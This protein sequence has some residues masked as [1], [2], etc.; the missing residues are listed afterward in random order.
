[1]PQHRAS[2][3]DPSQSVKQDEIQ[4]LTSL[5]TPDTMDQP[6]ALMSNW[7]EP[8]FVL[9]LATW[10]R[11][12]ALLVCPVRGRVSRALLACSPR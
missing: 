10:Q 11:G 12:H 6:W 3:R 8:L 2:A 4:Q 1:M 7:Q 9:E 5:L